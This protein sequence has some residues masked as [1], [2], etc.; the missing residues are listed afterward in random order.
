MPVN[1]AATFCATLVEEW[2][3]AGVSAAMVAPGSRSTPLALALADHP[4]IRLEV[5][6]DERSAGFAALGHGLATGQPAVVLC[7]SGTAGTHFHAAVVEADL[8]SVPMLVVTADRPPELLDVGA[9]Q[10]I[11]QTRLFGHSVRWFHAP[12]PPDEQLSRTWRSLARRSYRATVDTRPGPVHLNL[13][14]REPLVGEA[15]PLPGGE[16]EVLA[17]SSPRLDLTSLEALVARMDRQRGVIIAGRGAGERSSDVDAVERL[18]SETGW[19]VLADPRSGCRHLD[20]AVWTADAL[21]RHEHFARDHTPEVVLHIGDPWASRVTNEWLTS[22][23]AYHV[24][25]SALP[26]PLD[27]G[28]V[29]RQWITA[30]VGPTCEW[31]ATRLQGARG[32][33]WSSRWRNSERVAREAI[34]QALDGMQALTEPTIARLVASQVGPQQTVRNL[35]LSS[36]MPVRDVEWY[37]PVA[38]GAR[39]YSNRGANGIDGVIATAIGVAAA[40]GPTV[41]LIGDV[42]FLHDST[43]L[44]ALAHRGVD[45]RIVVVDNDGGGIFSFLSQASA[46]PGERFEQLFGTPHGTDLEALCRAHHLPVVTANDAESLLAALQTAGPSVVL[47]RSERAANVVAHQRI[48]RAVHDALR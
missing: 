47:L 30:P 14:F 4:G 31:L 35:V 21:L 40:V 33:T 39:V 23:G 9:A 36:S 17:V 18:S 28:H 2:V 37:A 27:P 24:H 7:S 11:D 44:T 20:S 3:G 42:A 8:S 6:H 12:G 13:A 38:V 48:N 26:R 43:S 34:A 45:L 32:T 22:S 25:L 5:F 15:G 10:T 1:P 16:P 29:M 41:V 46:L 19:P